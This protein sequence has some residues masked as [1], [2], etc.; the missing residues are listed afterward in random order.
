MVNE[1]QVIGFEDL[2]I[3]GMVKNRNL[4]KSILDAAWGMTMGMVKYKSEWYGRTMIKLNRFYAS[5]K[6]C[7]CCGHVMDEL[8]LQ[9][10][11]WTCPKCLSVHDRDENASKNLEMELKKAAGHVA[12]AL[13]SRKRNNIVPLA[14]SKDVVKVLYA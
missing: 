11:T 9:V 4:S 13:E 6:T 10:R 7:S 14:A 3:P 12:S 1:N 5:S 2:N 8:P